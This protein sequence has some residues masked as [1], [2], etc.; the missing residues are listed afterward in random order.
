MAASS[1][2]IPVYLYRFLVES[3]LEQSDFLDP[4]EQEL[5]TEA[6]EILEDL[7]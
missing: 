1:V 4:E 7:D 6:V 3:A 5:L 2:R